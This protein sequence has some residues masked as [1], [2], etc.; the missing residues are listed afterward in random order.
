MN[1]VSLVFLLIGVLCCMGWTTLTNHETPPVQG[2]CQAY[3]GGVITQ[4]EG[5]CKRGL[6]E[7][8]GRTI[9]EDY[10]EGRFKKGMPHG[11]GN[12]YWENGDT[13][14]GIWKKG[15]KDGKGTL[16]L[17]RDGLADSVVI[18]VWREDE[19]IGTGQTER[20][21]KVT[22]NL[23]V[24][25]Y[26]FQKISDEI[27][28]VEIRIT[29]NTMPFGDFADL[30]FNGTS[31][32]PFNRADY[33]GHSGVAYPFTGNISLSAPTQFRTSFYSVLLVYEIYE[34]GQWVITIE[35]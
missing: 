29:R 28:E 15:M 23:N 27:N 2:G 13:F 5:D 6:A 25:K 19:Y 12:F 24:R 8:F 22:R 20:Q 31:G 1:K 4:Y 18:G 21:Y 9:G 30:V 17:K 32:V 26:R 7:G 16:V 35:V 11:K 14:E 34:P 3:L 33:R 10:Y